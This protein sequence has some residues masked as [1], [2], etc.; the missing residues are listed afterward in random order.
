MSSPSDG[1]AGGT[2]AGNGSGKS[3]SMEGFEEF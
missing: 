1:F 2:G 3:G